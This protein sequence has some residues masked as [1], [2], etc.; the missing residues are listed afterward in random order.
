MRKYLIMTVASLLVWQLIYQSHMVNPMFLP[1][2]RETFKEAVRLLQTGTILWDVVYSLQRVFIGIGISLLFGIPA[3][4]LLGSHETLFSYGECLLDF[5]RSIPP[6]IT[7]PLSLLIF[8]V[9]DGSRI[10]VIVFGASTVMMLNTALGVRNSSAKRVNAAKVM[11][12]SYWQ[13]FWR[14]IFFEAMPQIFIGIRIC[15]SMGLI[16]GI[17]TEMMVGAP[18]GLGSRAMYAQISYNTPE[19][20]VTILL[21]GFIGFVINKGLVSLENEIVHWRQQG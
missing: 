7:F 13:I 17:V 1:E 20:Y 18:H 12:A 4:L 19:L 8:G 11:G 10:A 3:G 6:I 15:L 5:L 16:I 9:G 21:V 14:I 2:P